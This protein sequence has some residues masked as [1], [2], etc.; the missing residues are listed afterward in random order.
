[1]TKKLNVL[2][3]KSAHIKGSPWKINNTLKKIVGLSY[4]KA[5]AYLI[6]TN[7]TQS[8]AIF[9]LLKSFNKFNNFKYESE[10]IIVT[11][12]YANKSLSL[13]RLDIKAKSKSG[14]KKKVRCKTIIGV[15][16]KN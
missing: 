13:K 1:M 9:K 14:V 8:I 16:N 10:N 6:T 15:S 5:L 4:R 3:I 7:T 11:Y 12:A 2:F